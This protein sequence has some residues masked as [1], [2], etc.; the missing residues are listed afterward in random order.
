MF[1]RAQLCRPLGTQLDPGCCRIF[2][3]AA[4]L[5][6][7]ALVLYL[8]DISLRYIWPGGSA[9]DQPAELETI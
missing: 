1:E 4:R 7:Q 6:Q 5:A 2:T 3:A 8:L 9:P